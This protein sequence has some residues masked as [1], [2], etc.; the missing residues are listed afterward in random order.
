MTV[1][2]WLVRVDRLLLA[3]ALVAASGIACAGHDAAQP[4]ASPRISRASASTVYNATR[5]RAVGTEAQVN[6]LAR[7]FLPPSR[8]AHPGFAYYA[9]LLFTD[10][11]PTSAPARRAASATYL[12][13]LT[14]VQPA[15]QKSGLRREDMAVLYVPLADKAAADSLIR[16]RDPQGL[17]AAY[18]YVRAR[19]MAG[20]LKRAGKTIPDVA[21][22]GCSRPLAVQSVVDFDTVDVVDL[23]D[24]GTVRERM[25]RFRDS[26]E[27]GER[28]VSEG[29]QAVV[30]RRL[31]EFFTWAEA[32]AHDAS[33]VLTF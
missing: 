21:I 17:L 8:E 14:Q 31:R 25:E 16:D 6:L 11:S 22:I 27:S 26:L 15:G 2:E 19:G 4:T 24:P 20:L 18:N 1:L 10:S 29:G 30:L 9:Y 5:K 12:D 23:T 32:A 13:M 28:H 33:P 3:A 7:A